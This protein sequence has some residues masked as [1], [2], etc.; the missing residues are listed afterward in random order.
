[1]DGSTEDC[2][3]VGH[4]LLTSFSLHWPLSLPSPF[5]S[6]FP[7]HCSKQH[8]DGFICRE[9]AQWSGNDRWHRFHPCSTGPNVMPWSEM[10]WFQMTGDKERLRKVFPPLLAYHIWMRTNWT[11]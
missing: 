2:C 9:I 4:A 8:P 6:A 11:W 10:E 7:Y 1:M 5:L 3:T